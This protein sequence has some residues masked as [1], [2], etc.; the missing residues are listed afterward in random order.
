MD[1]G[2]KTLREQVLELHFAGLAPS[3]IAEAVEDVSEDGARRIVVD[4][5]E[6][7]RLERAGRRGG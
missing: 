2:K 4:A 1:S 5:W 6:K 7:D 3:Q